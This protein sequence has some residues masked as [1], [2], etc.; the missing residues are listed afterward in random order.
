ML[1]LAD[2]VANHPIGLVKVRLCTLQLPGR[3]PHQGL[4][5]TEVGCTRAQRQLLGLRQA[6]NALC[7]GCCCGLQVGLAG[8][9][10]HVLGRGQRSK[11]RVQVCSGVTKLP[12]GVGC[13]CA[14]RGQ[15]K[16]AQA[17][18]D[19]PNAGGDVGRGPTCLAHGFLSVGE[20]VAG[21][22]PA[23]NVGGLTGGVVCAGQRLVGRRHV[24]IKRPYP[25]GLGRI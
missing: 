11:A 2:P 8:L 14:L 22:R 6:A 25:R 1:A 13:S 4:R 24:G 12:S 18:V 17:L 7:N 23:Q 9:S 3:L 16:V 15:V 20:L 10:R 19:L 5:T 21:V